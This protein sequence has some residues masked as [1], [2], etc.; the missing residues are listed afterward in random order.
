MSTDGLFNYIDSV[1]GGLLCEGVKDKFKTSFN[2]NKIFR[3]PY[4]YIFLKIANA[5]LEQSIDNIRK[6]FSYHSVLFFM[7]N[8]IYRWKQC[9]T[10][11]HDFDVQKNLF[12]LG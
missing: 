9:A 11:M 6:A 1:R 2:Q 12:Y 4:M 8:L 3:N 10:H 5:C 7:I